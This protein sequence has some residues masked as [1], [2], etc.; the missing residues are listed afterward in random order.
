MGGAIA[1][2]FSSLLKG[3][4]PAV[5][6]VATGESK[7]FPEMMQKIPLGR[8]SSMWDVTGAMDD[9]FRTGGDKGV[10]IQQMH[11]QWQVARAQAQKKLQAPITQI[12]DAIAED[13][14]LSSKVSLNS[15]LGDIHATMKAQNHP[16]TNVAGS[17]AGPTGDGF[18]KTLEQHS[19]GVISQARMQ[20]SAQIYGDKMQNLFPHI[21]DAFDSKDPL[22]ET[23]ARTVLNVISRET[24]DN[25]QVFNPILDTTHEVSGV[26]S[27]I[28]KAIKRE[29]LM[30]EKLGEDRPQ[31][32]AIDVSRTY[33]S[34]GTM[35][36]RI[37]NILR[38]V[39]LPFVA[40]KHIS[41]IGNLSSIPAPML[42]KGLLSMGDEEFKTH[43]DISA[44]LAYTDHDMMDKQIRGRF[45]LISKITGNPTAG[46]LF[47]RSYHM[48]LFNYVRARQLT[49]AASVGYHSAN[50]WAK[51]LL[52]G[53][54]RAL[55]EIKEM[56]LDPEQILKQKGILTNEQKTQAMF[57][58]VNNRFF[59]DKSIERSMAA[60][61]HPILRSATMYHTFINAQQRFMRRELAKMVRAR[62]FVGI[63]QFA[64]TIGVLY[65]MVAPMLKSLEVFG[66]TFSPTQAGR[67]AREDYDKLINGSFGDRAGTYLDLLAHYGSLGIYNGYLNAAKTDRFAYQLLGPNIAVGAR[68]AGDALKSALVTNQAGKHNL[69][70][71][72]RDLLELVPIIGSPIAHK[73]APT[74]KEQKD[75]SGRLPRPHR[76]SR[77]QSG[78]F[79]EF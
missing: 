42:I 9:V 29:N 71:P 45:G 79:W 23:W 76:P 15:K 31:L 78:N 72:V 77:R 12:S 40:L 32:P 73:V 4:G 50:V 25:T 38:A 63:G 19:T 14:N 30:R 70:P 66:R 39:Q 60:S 17:L 43:L 36:Y 58:F 53:N 7:E 2:A 54:K 46:D 75:E 69:A 10:K 44:I 3:L 28:Q 13:N 1:D 22:Q 5:K 18:L 52:E 6:E 57:Q 26:K 24:H 67:S 47:Y 56:G 64:G 34:A 59:M 35:E 11:S 20:A 37:N 21:I 62:D 74:L 61:S 8:K 27:Q 16:L 49:M 51:Q 65:P 55:E 33:I 41:Q 68:F 48:P